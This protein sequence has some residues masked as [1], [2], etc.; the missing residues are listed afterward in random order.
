[1]L[2]R[3]REVCRAVCGLMDIGGVR[4][5]LLMLGCFVC[6]VDAIGA[7]FIS[8]TA[9]AVWLPIALAAAMVGDTPYDAGSTSPVNT[10]VLGQKYSFGDC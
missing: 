2:W 10:L 4:R 6:L 1:M 7:Y 5:P 3:G 9:A 8:N